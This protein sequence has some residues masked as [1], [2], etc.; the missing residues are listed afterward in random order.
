MNIN[1]IDIS[2]ISDVQYITKKFEKSM[3]DFLYVYD[4]EEYVG[5]YYLEDFCNSKELEICDEIPSQSKEEFTEE[6]KLLERIEKLDSETLQLANDIIKKR[7]YSSWVCCCDSKSVAKKILKRLMGI[8]EEN[9]KYVNSIYDL[10]N[11]DKVIFLSYRKIKLYRK[12][13]LVEIEGFISINNLVSNCINKKFFDN[14][15]PDLFEYLK[16]LN[17][18]IIYGIIPEI[19]DLTCLSKVAKDRIAGFGTA[20][21]DF[22]AEILGGRISGDFIACMAQNKV[23]RV[24]NNGIFKK[25]EDCQS[26]FYNVIGGMRFTAYQPDEYTNTIYIFGPCTVRG[27][28]VE[29][30]NTV[31][32]QLQKKINDSGYKYIVMNC[33]VGGGSDLENTYKYILSMPL[34]AGDII[35]LIEEGQFLKDK[36][37]SF[38]DIINLSSEF[39]LN[40]LTEEWFVDRPAHCNSLANAKIT[41]C[42]YKKLIQVIAENKVKNESEMIKLFK[43]K[44]KIHKD[45][46]ELMQYIAKISENKFMVSSDSCV[47]AIAMHCNPMTKGHKYL[48]EEALRQVDYL[49]IFILSEDK[50][51]IPYSIRKD[52]L[53]YETKQYD[54]VKVLDCGSFM[55]STSSFPEY[56]MKE[57][58]ISSRVDASKDILTFCQ[59]VV[60]A[61]NITKRFVGTERRDFVTRQYNNQLKMIL[62]YYGVEVCEIE[63]I[64]CV[65]GSI[66]AFSTREMIKNNLWKDVKYMVTDYVYAR[67]QEYYGVKK[68]DDNT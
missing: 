4:N 48:I 42:I 38:K 24:V 37:N 12:S 6:K 45:S 28:L 30:K 53:M 46:C 21:Y 17:I 33:G 40:P 31:A 55:A 5:V 14:K 62:P 11:K 18:G 61:L 36:I 3:T 60:P 67:L 22:Y 29:D 43:G 63:R 54:N 7:K 32:S 10:D 59:Y 26:D 19:D 56:F 44:Q 1:S 25:L 57:K 39:N 41:N 34:K 8:D 23:S 58:S 20:D 64:N 50:T 68:Y 52:M 47:G 51:D 66:S 65:K 27:A 15:Y 16:K 2:K 9:I 49:Y 35:I 13:H